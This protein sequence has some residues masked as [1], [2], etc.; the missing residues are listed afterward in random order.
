MRIEH[1][2][3]GGSFFAALAINL[4]VA[5]GADRPTKIGVLTD[6]NGPY[7]AIT[8]KGSVIASQLAIQDFATVVP[9]RSVELIVADHM[10]KPD[11]GA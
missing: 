8:G 11:V 3:R 10:Q 4:T 2:L 6:M 9:D 5:Y 7:S 1:T